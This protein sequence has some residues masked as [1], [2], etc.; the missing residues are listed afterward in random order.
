MLQYHKNDFL[1]GI[2]TNETN[3]SRE[4][5]LFQYWY[6]KHAGFR[7]EPHISNKCD[8]VLMIA[9]ELKKHSIY[10]VR[11]LDVFYGALLGMRLLL[12]WIILC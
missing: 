9:Y 11:I 3:A 5:M 6:F 7:I 4:F 1:E 2:G 12:G 8:D 10:K